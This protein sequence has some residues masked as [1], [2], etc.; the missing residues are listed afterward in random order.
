MGWDAKAVSKGEL[1]Y[2][3]F[4]EARN[5][6]LDNCVT[7]DGN[8]KHGGLDCRDCGRMLERAT[9]ESVYSETYWHPDKVKDLAGYADWDFN[10]RRGDEWAYWSARE[11]LNTCALYGYAIKFSW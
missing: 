5:R 9:D 8:L 4:N 3:A 2:I 11:F 10:P 1:N 6:V 7:V